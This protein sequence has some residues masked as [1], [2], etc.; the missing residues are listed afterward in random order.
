MTFFHF[1]SWISDGFRS[2][3]TVCECLLIVFDPSEGSQKDGNILNL[4][5]HHAKSCH[6]PQLRKSPE[7]KFEMSKFDVQKPFY[8][9]SIFDSFSRYFRGRGAPRARVVLRKRVKPLSD[10]VCDVLT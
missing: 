6:I 10:T 7:E 2:I 4:Y 3:C 9:F 8:D 1:F 5:N